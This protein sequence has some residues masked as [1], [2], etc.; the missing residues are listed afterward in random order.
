MNPMNG[1]VLANNPIDE[2]ENFLNLR[3]YATERRGSNEVVVAVQGKWNDMLIFFSFEENMRCLHVSFLINIE[4]QIENKSKIFELLALINDD[5]WMGHFSYWAEQKMMVYRHSLFCNEKS[6]H[7]EGQIAQIM[8]IAIKEC[9][10]M[11]PVFNVVMTKGM[12]PTQALY[13]MMMETVGQ[14]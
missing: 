14:A 4:N 9:E 10:R 13:P 2:V 1:T 3:S 11:Y 7:F 8:D 5:L 6:I 12:E